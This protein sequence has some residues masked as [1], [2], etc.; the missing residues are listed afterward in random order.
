MAVFKLLLIFSISVI[1]SGPLSAKKVKRL[2]IK[3]AAV[4][5]AHSPWGKHI[6][7]VIKKYFSDKKKYKNKVFFSGSMGGEKTI[8]RR[9]RQGRIEVVGVTQAALSPTVPE[10]S[11]MELPFMFES[12]EEFDYVQ[13]KVMR[14]EFERLMVKRGFIPYFYPD[15]GFR[16]IATLGKPFRKISDIQGLKM[17]AQ[18]N[19]LYI[20]FYQALGAQPIPIAVPEVLSA[21]QTGV[22]DGFDQSILFSFTSAWIEGIKYFSL[23][24][25]I[26]QATVL[27]WSKKFWDTHFD[28]KSK[29]MVR[30]TAQSE[31]EGSRRQIRRLN[32]RIIKEMRRTGV[33]VFRP[34]PEVIKEMKRRTRIVHQKFREDWG[35]DVARLLDKAYKGAKDYR[36]GK[37]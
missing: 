12:A 21:L 11:I 7:R 5:T 28:T 29:E 1:I 2:S 3:Y 24:E 8:I 36:A 32:K 10:L 26:Y 20:D 31:T 22:I 14:K 18:E 15:N 37:R 35:P 4:A 19:R 9:C 16:M 6:R 27:L 13:D 30:N 33:K 25:H 34:K 17:R 23:T